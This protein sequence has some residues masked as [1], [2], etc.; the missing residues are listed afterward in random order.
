M[1]HVQDLQLLQLA[2][3]V[4][5][6]VALDDASVHMQHSKA[7][8][9]DD[10]PRWDFC[11]ACS[12]RKARLQLLTLHTPAWRQN[13]TLHPQEV[14]VGKEGEGESAASCMKLGAEGGQGITMACGNGCSAYKG[15][16]ECEGCDWGKGAH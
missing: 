7:V 1:R 13:S 10:V 2:E 11:T 14:Q 9:A 12:T 8:Q 15:Q 5:A 16:H 3:A 4:A 6:A